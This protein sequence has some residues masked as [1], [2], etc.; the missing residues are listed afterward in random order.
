MLGE[1]GFAWNENVEG[2]NWDIIGVA[3]ESIVFA[4]F[5][6]ERV[7]SRLYSKIHPTARTIPPA[8][9]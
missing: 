6:L 5:A 1:L 7:R 4:A 9:H 3:I 8:V 2:A